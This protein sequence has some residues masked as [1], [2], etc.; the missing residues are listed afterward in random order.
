MVVEFP[1]LVQLPFSTLREMI[2]ELFVRDNFIWGEFDFSLNFTFFILVISH[3]D[4]RT[5]IY[6]II[7]RVKKPTDKN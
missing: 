4:L 1:F 7:L 3:S 2:A 5:L 6:S